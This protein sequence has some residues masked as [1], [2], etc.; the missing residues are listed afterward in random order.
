[1]TDQMKSMI[2][3]HVKLAEQ[4]SSGFDLREFALS[5]DDEMK[6]AVMFADRIEFLFREAVNC[7]LGDLWHPASEP[8]K[9]NVSGLMVVYKDSTCGFVNMD[10]VE[11]VKLQVVAKKWL[12]LADLCLDGA[13][14]IEP[15]WNEMQNP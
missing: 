6:I 3:E 12:Y 1:M 5:R 4:Y 9:K 10:K 7:Y 2:G 14:E 15:G 8:P 11:E 13:D